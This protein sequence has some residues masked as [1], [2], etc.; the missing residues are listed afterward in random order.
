MATANEARVDQRRVAIV[1]GCGDVGSAVAHAIHRAGLGVV[2]IDQAH[3]A[4]PRRGMAFTDA[5]YLIPAV[6]QRCVSA[7]ANDLDVSRPAY[8][9][10]WPRAGLSSLLRNLHAISHH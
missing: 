9:P 3:P 6:I 7:S 4:W 2:I 5:W 8:S 1:L 10:R